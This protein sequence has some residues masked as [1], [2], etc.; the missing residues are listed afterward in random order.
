MSLSDGSIENISTGLVDGKIHH[1]DWSPDGEKFVFGGRRGGEAEF[2]FLE[3][4]LPLEKL[5][6]TPEIKMRLRFKLS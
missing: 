5:A 6:K 4:F 1:L 3:D 2:W